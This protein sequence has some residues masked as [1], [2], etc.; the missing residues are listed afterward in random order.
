M[1]MKFLSYLQKKIENEYVLEGYSTDRKLIS[2]GS[3]KK[4][5]HLNFFKEFS[6][7]KK[8]L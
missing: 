1:Q 5:I 7:Q 2:A 8:D 6:V 3:N 4:S